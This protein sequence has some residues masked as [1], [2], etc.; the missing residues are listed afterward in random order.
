MRVADLLYSR[1]GAFGFEPVH[2]RLDGGIRGAFLCRQGFLNLAHG[3]G[4]DP[5]DGVHDS[6]FHSRQLRQG[7]GAS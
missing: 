7:H 3:R 2:H 1:D 5:P 6:E 4:S